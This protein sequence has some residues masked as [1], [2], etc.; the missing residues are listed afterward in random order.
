MGISKSTYLVFVVVITV[1]VL[2]VTVFKGGEG[3]AN[4]QQDVR[5]QNRGS[6]QDRRDRYPVVEAEETEPSDPVKKA[7][8]KNKGSVT[9]R[10]PL[11]LIRVQRT[12]SSLSDQNGNLIF[13]L[14]RLLKVT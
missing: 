13:P 12:K 3:S 10:T 11:S 2:S 9:T 6:Y 7:K 4:V 5:A 8:L 14:Y 1:M